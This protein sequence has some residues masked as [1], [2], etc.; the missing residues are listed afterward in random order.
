MVV[1]IKGTAASAVS[2]FYFCLFCHFCIFLKVK[3]GQ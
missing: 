2:S 3:L 1:V